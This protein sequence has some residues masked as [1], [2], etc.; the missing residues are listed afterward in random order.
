M[1]RGILAYL[2]V[3]LI[4]VI[5]SMTPSLSEICLKVRDLDISGF[6]LSDDIEDLASHAGAHQELLS[7]IADRVDKEPSFRDDLC[8]LGLFQVIMDNIGPELVYLEPLSRICGNHRG[9]R[10]TIGS[11]QMMNT[12]LVN[13]ISAM[14]QRVD[15][16]PVTV[17]FVINV[18]RGITANKQKFLQL[19]HELI[20]SLS[21]SAESDRSSSLELLVCLLS[22]DDKINR[23]DPCVVMTRN[24]LMEN[25]SNFTALR[26][27]LKTCRDTKMK[28]L[29][30]SLIDIMSCGNSY[31]YI[32]AIDD[33]HLDWVMGVIRDCM[34]LDDRSTALACIKIIRTW[35][36]CDDLKDIIL[37][38][39]M[40]KSADL[41]VLSSELPSACK[42]FFAALANVSL[43]NP[44]MAL[45]ILEKL[46]HLEDLI[47]RTMRVSAFDKA[48]IPCMQFLRTLIRSEEGSLACRDLLDII[49]PMTT[50]LTLR[51]CD[52]RL[53]NEI[54]AKMKVCDSTSE[55]TAVEPT[56]N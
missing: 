4:T 43:R 16:E 33:G 29:T 52:R 36:F 7:A 46:P 37:V 51:E 13:A 23:S 8:D 47:N 30:L 35:S 10:A 39:I 27:I 24:T 9:L 42:H 55:S 32:L 56:G 15:F 49:E 12:G 54:T 44:A 6:E 41:V 3:A 31:S 19:V 34:A 5:A 25:G 53:A 50:N 14:I 48:R 22:D 1:S 26:N 17:S 28:A 20:S 21:M 18:C 2:S 40:D 11:S 45:S 38:K